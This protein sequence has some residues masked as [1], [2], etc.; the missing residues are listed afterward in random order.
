MSPKPYQRYSQEF[1]DKA[2][3][4]LALGKPVSEVAEDLQVSN[5]MLYT[6]RNQEQS[7]QG[8]SAGL[9]ATSLEDADLAHTI[10]TFK[11]EMLQNGRFI[12]A[13]DA[14]TEIFAFI[15]GDASVEP[16]Q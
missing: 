10:R 2:V 8:G 13:T 1:K 7:P 11:A 12:N 16:G 4:L 15:D 6:C 9:R 5:S 14:R 3:A